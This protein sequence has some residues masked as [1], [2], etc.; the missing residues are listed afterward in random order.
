MRGSPVLVT[1]AAGFVGRHLCMGLHEAG[2]QVHA[3]VRPGR[4]RSWLATLE[5][6]M[7]T[8]HE[9]D[10]RDY[11]AVAS[12][13][14]QIQP[15]TIFHAAVHDAYARASPLRELVA[16]NIL[17]TVHV[18]EAARA[19]NARVVQLGSSLEYG[20]ADHPHRET[21]PLFPTTRRGV[22][23]AV[24]TWLALCEA[25]SGIEAVVLRLFSVYGPWERPH[26]LIPTALRAAFTGEELPLTRWTCRRD[27]VYVEDI[28]EA[29]LL[30]AT[31]GGISGQAIN[32][33]TGIQY[34]NEEVVAEIKRVTGKT[35]RVQAGSYPPHEIDR[36]IWVAD[37]S[38]AQKLLGWRPRHSLADG[39]RKTASWCA[40]EI[41]YGSK[42]G[43]R[44]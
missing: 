43:Q 13:V 20:P 28:V 33:A 34:T 38:K 16:D 41:G 29:C 5:G 1:G 24:G 23:K 31:T 9:T 6:A 25:R 22:T 3:L 2:A 12:L 44:G 35:I 8:V 4:S 7:P 19:V 17:A 40:H 39:L 21:D 18:L 11:P 42:A 15:R 10:L 14:E 32:I 26:R 27:F 30:A 37:I 36:P